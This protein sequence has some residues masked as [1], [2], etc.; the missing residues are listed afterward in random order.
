MQTTVTNAH[1]FH[2]S[3][4][5]V[6]RFNLA[7]A[8]QIPSQWKL[9]HRRCHYLQHYSHANDLPGRLLPS[10]GSWEGQDQCAH[11]QDR[12]LADDATPLKD[13]LPAI[14]AVFWAGRTMTSIGSFIGTTITYF[15]YPEQ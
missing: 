6:K 11:V 2:M 1:F 14:E 15:A 10:R 9:F 8:L 3:T 5:K 12:M 7:G 13:T 4:R